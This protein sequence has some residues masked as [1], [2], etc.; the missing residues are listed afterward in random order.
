[1][2]TSRWSRMFLRYAGISLV[3]LL[4]LYVILGGLNGWGG[5]ETCAAIGL[6]MVLGAFLYLK[7]M[8]NITIKSISQRI[9]SEYPPESQTQVFEAY[10]HLKTRELEGLF[11]KILDDAHGDASQAKRLT[12]VA[13]GVGWQS[14]L[15]NKW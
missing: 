1:M 4:I 2:N 11:P 5:S 9:R 8:E 14:F 10:E 7:Q 15:D 12:S 3:I 13:E 6:L